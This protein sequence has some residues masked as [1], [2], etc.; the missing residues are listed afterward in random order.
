VLLISDGAW[1][2]SVD[3]V[4][5]AYTMATQDIRPD[6]RGGQYVYT[7]TVYVF[8]DA[9]TT[10][11]TQGRQAMITTAI[12]GGF[13]DKDGNNWPYPFTSYPSD[14]R[15]VV[16][17]LPQCDPSGTWNSQCAEWDTEFNSPR[18]GLPYNFYEVVDLTTLDDALTSAFIDIL[19]RGSSSISFATV[20]HR[21]FS[22]STVT[23]STS[24][25]SIP[26]LIVQPYYYPK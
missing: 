15:N 10:T 11:A 13:D 8:G 21:G 5:P 12:F 23:I 22:R 3:P 17:P 19:R 18:D 24:R 7:Y 4:I 20:V 6:L 25:V 14:S 2:G 16:Y 26:Y 9:G 1:N